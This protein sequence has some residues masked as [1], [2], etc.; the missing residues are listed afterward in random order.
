HWCPPGRG[1]SAET[2]GGVYPVDDRGCLRGDQRQPVVERLTP[3]MMYASPAG[4]IGCRFCGLQPLFKLPLRG[5][6]CGALP[7]R[8]GCGDLIPTPLLLRCIARISSFTVIAC[9]HGS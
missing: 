6:S 1:D 8:P 4:L 3:F 7:P 5:S 9:G 2:G